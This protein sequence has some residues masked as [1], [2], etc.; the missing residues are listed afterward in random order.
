MAQG[1]IEK[2]SREIKNS[3]ETQGKLAKKES[4]ENKYLGLPDLYNNIEYDMCFPAWRDKAIGK[5]QYVL[6]SILP[7]G[8][9]KKDGGSIV[10][11][12]KNASG[13][14]RDFKIS[15]K[16]IEKGDMENDDIP[17]ITGLVQFID[18]E[19][20]KEAQMAGDQAAA[21]AAPEGAVAA[22]EG[23]V[24]NAIPQGMEFEE[25][26]PKPQYKPDSSLNEITAADA[27]QLT[28]AAQQEQLNERNNKIINKRIKELVTPEEYSKIMS[29]L[30][31]ALYEDDLGT[32]QIFDDKGN[33][34][35]T[36]DDETEALQQ[37]IQLIES[38]LSTGQKKASY[39]GSKYAMVSIHK[40]NNMPSMVTQGFELFKNLDLKKTSDRKKLYSLVEL[41]Q[42]GIK[43]SDFQDEASKSIHDTYRDPNAKYMDRPGK[44]TKTKAYNLQDI[45]KLKNFASKYF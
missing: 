23:A 15:S 44:L 41:M 43:S 11:V 35:A 30:K 18:E 21:V 37:L 12:I 42:R 19:L 29:T 26:L 20:Q 17:Y 7:K 25:Y 9:A 10:V 5:Q 6:A 27:Q 31:K 13:V 14:E 33:V 3:L 2:L 28:D 1:K 8:G 34:V 22:P 38:D 4:P 45:T 40:E 32:V 39:I 36:S 24:V 16:H